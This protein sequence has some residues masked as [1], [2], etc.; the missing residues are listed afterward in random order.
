MIE[1]PLA[2]CELGRRSHRGEQP[3]RRPRDPRSAA[4]VGARERAH[5]PQASL[6]PRQATRHDPPTALRLVHQMFSKLLCW[7]VLRARS[8]ATNEIDIPVL[9]HQ[10]AG[11]QRRIPVRRR[12]GLPAVR[13]LAA[14]RAGLETTRGAWCPL[15]PAGSSG[16]SQRRA[17]CAR[18]SSTRRARPDL[19]RRTRGD[20][21]A[22]R[23]GRPLREN[24]AQ[25]L[26]STGQTGAE[27]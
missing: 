15:T 18:C 14:L 19:R 12:L 16:A 24:Y 8:D 23:A 4:P 25:H 1:S 27:R 11:L 26:D 7:I 13:H 3:A 20:R 2:G 9:R 21:C 5:S 6:R 17:T 10:F 22:V